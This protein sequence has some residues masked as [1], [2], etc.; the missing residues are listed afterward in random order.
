MRVDLEKIFGKQD[1]GSHNT[2]DPK[3]VSVADEK[4]EKPY[5]WGDEFGYVKH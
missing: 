2:V 5:E 4:Y 3:S 1:N